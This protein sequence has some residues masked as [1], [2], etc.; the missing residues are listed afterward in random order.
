[1]TT[2]SLLAVD[3]VLAVLVTAG[4]LGGAAGGR[5]SAVAGLVRRP[6]GGGVGGGVP[7]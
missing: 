4:W 3:L 7:G 5:Q 1:M 2:G 6:A